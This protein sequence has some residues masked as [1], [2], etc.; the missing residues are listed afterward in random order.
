MPSLRKKVFLLG[1]ILLLLIRI[2]QTLIEKEPIS[3][4]STTDGLSQPRKTRKTELQ[5]NINY[6][7]AASTSNNEYVT[8]S[9]CHLTAVAY[10]IFNPNNFAKN[11]IKVS[12][13]QANDMFD[14]F[15]KLSPDYCGQLVTSSGKQYLQEAGLNEHIEILQVDLPQVF[16]AVH[17]WSATWYVVEYYLANFAKT[18]VIFLDIDILPTFKDV[19]YIFK[20]QKWDFALTLTP[21]RNEHDRINVGVMLVHR[22]GLASMASFSSLVIEEVLYLMAKNYSGIINQLAPLNVLRRYGD[23][24]IE[25]VGEIKLIKG[26][27]TIPNSCIT[28]RF[29]KKKQEKDILVQLLHFAEWNTIPE[30]VHSF[31]KFIHF[32][33]SRKAQMH[34]YFLKLNALGNSFLSSK[35]NDWCARE[36]KTIN[37]RPHKYISR[38]ECV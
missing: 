32:R 30:E 10:L 8:N 33:G 27:N 37:C 20:D 28:L 35:K 13:D 34:E 26:K 11:K 15:L 17:H 29:N 16:V 7:D 19:L 14:T 22:N 18:H 2:S 9:K 4:V 1:G 31:S 24:K 23:K 21:Y 3:I 6:N 36:D 5:V 12:I 25:P 38:N